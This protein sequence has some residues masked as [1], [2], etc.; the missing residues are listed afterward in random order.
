[1]NLNAL[2]SDKIDRVEFDRLMLQLEQK[3]YSSFTNGGLVDSLGKSLSTPKTKIQSFADPLRGQTRISLTSPL[4][5]SMR[6]LSNRTT[7]PRVRFTLH[8][9][10][11][12]CL[13]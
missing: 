4:L 6:S 1:M 13:I 7:T 9:S 11:S 5:S 2:N 10:S 8:R 3:Y 12:I